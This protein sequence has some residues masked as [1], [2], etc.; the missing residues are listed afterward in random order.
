MEFMKT[1]LVICLVA[2]IITGL[3]YLVKSLEIVG[4]LSVRGFGQYFWISK[5]I[6]NGL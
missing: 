2:T 3:Y 5:K 1:F 6:K 4:L